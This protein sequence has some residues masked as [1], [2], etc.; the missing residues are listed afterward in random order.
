M[1][2]IFTL[3]KVPLMFLYKYEVHN[4]YCIIILNS[5]LLF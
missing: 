4:D 5:I 1:D 3:D 2:Y